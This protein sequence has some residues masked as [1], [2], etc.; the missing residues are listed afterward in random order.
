[1][2]KWNVHFLSGVVAVLFYGC[3][4]SD[5]RELL[6][7]GGIFVIVTLGLGVFIG[8]IVKSMKHKQWES[9]GIT[10]KSMSDSEPPYS[11]SN[12]YIIGFFITSLIVFIAC[13]I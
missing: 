8:M 9:Q 6:V 4:F 13:W 3:E 11:Y 1:M 12:I 10:T 7:S 2:K 5:Y